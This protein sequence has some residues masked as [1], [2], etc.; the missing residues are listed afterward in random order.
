LF[1]DSPE[2]SV[3]AFAAIS[4]SNG[5]AGAIG[6]FT[7]SYTSRDVMASIVTAAAGL[8]LICYWIMAIIHAQH[9]DFTSSST[10]MAKYPA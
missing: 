4:F 7:F 5:F 10:R 6:Y 2:N 1:A 9:L 8:A 3:S